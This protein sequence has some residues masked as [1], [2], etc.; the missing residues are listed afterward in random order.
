MIQRIKYATI[1][2]ICV[3]DLFFYDEKRTKE[4][5]KFCKEN[6]ISYLPSKDR[7]SVFRLSG[8]HFEKSELGEWLIL[9]PND[10]IF[11][12]KTIEK[13]KEVNHN[14]IRF[15]LS[16]DKIVGVVHLIDYNKEFIYTELYRS[17]YQFEQN[18]RYLLKNSNQTNEHFIRWAIDRSENYQKEKERKYW[19]KRIEDIRPGDPDKD[20]LRKAANPFQTFLLSDLLSYVG[21]LK[22][23]GDVS[24]HVNR[25]KRSVENLRNWVMHSKDITATGSPDVSDETNQI[26]YNYDGAKKFIQNSIDFFDVYDAINEVN[27]KLGKNH[28]LSI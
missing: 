26:I 3:Y 9:S 20:T 10:L 5:V 23:L 22:E 17:L 15:V 28:Y 11:S 19:K 25:S 7:R 13:F 27:I 18:I 14:E 6:N 21:S 12:E 1:A 2:D 8:D 24:K 4:L 16:D